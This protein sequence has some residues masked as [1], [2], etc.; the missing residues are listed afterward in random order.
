MLID[1]FVSV[2]LPALNQIRGFCSASLLVN[3]EWGRAA[4]SVAY[5][6]PD[7]VSRRLAR[8][9]GQQT[10]GNNII[11]VRDFDMVMPHL[12]VPDLASY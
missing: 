11:V 9:D 5:D 10:M 2:T 12:R 1:D 7:A 3:R 8:S 4:V 6:N